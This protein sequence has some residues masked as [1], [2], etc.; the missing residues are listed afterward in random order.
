MHSERA[1][2]VPVGAAV[3]QVRKGLKY[4]WEWGEASDVW[5]ELSL[6]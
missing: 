5:S 6:S 2:L 4:M 1:S 3:V